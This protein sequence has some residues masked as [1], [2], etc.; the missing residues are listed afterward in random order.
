MKK[1]GF[2]SSYSTIDTIMN[3]EI[4]IDLAIKDS[5]VSEGLSKFY[6]KAM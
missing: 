5:I 1:H 4:S 2:Q 6:H 3:K